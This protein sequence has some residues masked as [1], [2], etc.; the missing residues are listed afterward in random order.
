MTAVKFRH[1]GRCLNSSVDLDLL[2]VWTLHIANAP[3]LKLYS[4][5]TRTIY[6]VLAL[7]KHIKLQV[8]GHSHNLTNII[9]IHIAMS[10]N[11]YIIDYTP[12]LQDYLW[13]T[14]IHYPYCSKTLFH[15]VFHLVC[16]C[17]LNVQ[18][19]P[20]EERFVK[21]FLLEV[22]LFYFSLFFSDAILSPGWSTIEVQV[23]ILTTWAGAPIFDIVMC[24]VGVLSLVVWIGNVQ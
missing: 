14:L 8:S 11:I 19:V 5:T 21:P 23:E 3:L 24:G 15:R 17:H 16:M 20:F 12:K 9:K 1:F 6:F 2:E 13:Y 22:F 10:S 4:W 7:A 18:T